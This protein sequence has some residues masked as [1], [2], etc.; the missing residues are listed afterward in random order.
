MFGKMVPKRLL[1]KLIWISLTIRVFPRM[2]RNSS[3]MK[4]TESSMLATILRSHLWIRLKLKRST[5]STC[6][7]EVSFPATLSE[8]STSLA[9]IL[10][11]AVVL[12]AITL[13]RW[14]GSES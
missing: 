6:I 13:P 9:L 1:N 5:V 8:W 12:I 11:P 14:V 3:K 4:L 7:R 2:K 10:K